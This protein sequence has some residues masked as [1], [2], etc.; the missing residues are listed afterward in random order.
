MK[1]NITLKSLSRFVAV[2]A[3]YNSDFTDNTDI[4]RE[5]FL[6]KKDFKLKIDFDDNLAKNKF[7]KKYFGELL[8]IF[9][10]KKDVID[11]L[12]IDNLGNSWDIKRLPVVLLAILRVAISEMMIRPDI[13]IGI[14]IS[15]YLRLT[16]SFC[17]K[18]ECAFANAILEKI[19]QS[20]KFG[21]N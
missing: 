18:K 19:Y 9:D 16:E 3:I 2:Q 11:N 5:Y 6:S 4:M 1:N 17:S 14:I 13:S 7:N 15:E 12:I 21:K 10:K 8:D 20:N